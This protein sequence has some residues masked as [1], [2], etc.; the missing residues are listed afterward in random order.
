MTGGFVVAPDV[1]GVDGAVVEPELDGVVV[2]GFVVVGVTVVGATG[3][4]VAGPISWATSRNRSC[5]VSPI[6]DAR[7]SSGLPGISTMMM[8]FPCVLTSA[9]ATPAPLT[10][11]LMMLTAWSRFSLLTSPPADGFACKVMRWPPARSRP[12][13][14]FQL[15]SDAAPASITTMTNPKIASVRTGFDDLTATSVGPRDMWSASGSVSVSSTVDAS[16]VSSAESVSYAS[17]SYSSSCA[18]GVT[19]LP[20]APRWAL[21]TTPAPPRRRRTRP[22]SP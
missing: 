6:L 17:A 21:R 11:L 13:R 1:V 9:S 12:R 16:A 3:T 22:P 5:A 19:T 7:F 2:V 15:P 14:G 4:A 18:T 20:I 8:S 10:R